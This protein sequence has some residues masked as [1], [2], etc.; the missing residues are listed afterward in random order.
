MEDVRLVEDSALK[1]P[2]CN[3]FVGSIPMSSAKLYG[4]ISVT[5]TRYLVEIVL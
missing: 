5:A 2:D 3:R 1:A 4:V